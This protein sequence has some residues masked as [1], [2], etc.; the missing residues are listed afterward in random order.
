MSLAE[1]DD[2]YHMRVWA[3]KAHLQSPEKNE[4]SEGDGLG[5]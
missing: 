3:P 4:G 1:N 5:V 2:D